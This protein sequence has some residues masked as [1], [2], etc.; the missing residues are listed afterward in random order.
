M[1]ETGS[2]IERE[3]LERYRKSRNGVAGLPVVTPHVL[4]TMLGGL[5]G[6]LWGTNLLAQQNVPDVPRLLSYQG[7]LVEPDGVKVPDATYVVTIRLYEAANGGTPVWEE[8]Q[9]VV[10]L[11]GVFD[12]ILGLKTPLDNVPFD[13]QYWLAIELQ[14]EQEMTPRT[15]V[16]SAPYAMRAYRSS[17][18]DS[19]V[20]GHVASVNNIQGH[21][22]LQAGSGITIS[23]AGQD[24]TIS[25]TGSMGGDDDLTYGSIWYGDPSDRPTER[26]IGRPHDV[27]TVNGAGTEPVWSNRLILQSVDVDSLLVEGH[28][29]LT[30]T[31]LVDNDARF[32]SSVRFEQLPDFPLTKNAVLIGNDQNRAAE[33]RSTD[34]PGQVLRLDANGTPTW[35]DLDPAGIGIA[36]GRVQTT[37]QLRQTV[38][39]NA[40]NGASKIIVAYEDP[41]G[42]AVIPV[43]LVSQNPGSDFTVLFTALPPAGTF[44]IYTIMP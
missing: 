27:L 37:G 29:R 34:R 36:S 3:P 19:I 26:A 2:H 8:T 14:G 17:I 16:V 32:T 1:T 7:V 43:Q 4:A 44:L 9:S 28:A 10:T 20:G 40:V 22:A 33:Y 6:I 24:I 5:L 25:A 13:R 35:Q 41:S 31:V 21:I 23:G 39:E 15:M 30:G 42:G 18:T 12:A 38:T 11:D